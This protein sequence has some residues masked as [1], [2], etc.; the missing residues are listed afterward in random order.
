MCL[1]G[2]LPTYKLLRFIPNR[3]T[4]DHLSARLPAPLKIAVMIGTVRLWSR[5]SGNQSLGRY[6]LI[7][8][9]PSTNP[10]GRF[11]C[12]AEAIV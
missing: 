12:R 11:A 3:F 4:Y 7:G 10:K 2:K 6:H 5:H 8:Q 1:V 9:H